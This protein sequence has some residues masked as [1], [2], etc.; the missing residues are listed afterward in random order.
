[1]QQKTNAL[2]YDLSVEYKKQLR[3]ECRFPVA[4]GWANGK[5]LVKGY[6]AY[7]D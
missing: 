2:S 5:M 3:V 6:N 1:M 4:E 7:S